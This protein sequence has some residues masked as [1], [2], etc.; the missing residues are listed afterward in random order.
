MCAQAELPTQFSIIFQSNEVDG[1][2]A[3]K[4]KNEEWRSK[5]MDNRRKKE[6]PAKSKLVFTFLPD[7]FRFRSQ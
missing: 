2:R 1:K 7:Q 5:K 6:Q 3:K 4:E